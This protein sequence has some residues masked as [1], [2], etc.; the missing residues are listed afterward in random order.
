M[1]ENSQQQ[2]VRNTIADIPNEE[3]ARN[4][5]APYSSEFQV[6]NSAGNVAGS[7]KWTLE[8]GEFPF[9]DVTI[10]VE[11]GVYAQIRL[12]LIDN[13]A[14]T[15]SLE[16]LSSAE[17]KIEYVNIIENSLYTK[18]DYYNLVTNEKMGVS[19][20]SILRINGKYFA[21][22]MHL[23]LAAAPNKSGNRTVQI[24]FR[25]LKDSEVADIEQHA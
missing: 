18:V 11:K 17:I 7:F 15:L 5:L 22:G 6:L 14:T 13:S 1:M 23:D 12:R 19:K 9:A 16:N 2:M 8:N 24:T 20:G 21:I 10:E 3:R 4:I 25:P